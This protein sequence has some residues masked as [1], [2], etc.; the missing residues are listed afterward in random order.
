MDKK[1]EKDCKDTMK[2]ILKSVPKNLQGSL[3]ELARKA[4]SPE[5]LYR[6][7]MVGNCPICGSEKTR[8]LWTTRLSV[9]RRVLKT[10]LII[11]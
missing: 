5:E 7:V 1:K 10:P 9:N 4:G 8:G 6:L 11:R 2:E 3:F